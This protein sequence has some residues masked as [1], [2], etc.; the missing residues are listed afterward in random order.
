[1][2]ERGAIERDL[3]AEIRSRVERTHRILIHAATQLRLGQRAEA[4]LVEMWKENPELL[5]EC[6]ALDRQL[7]RASR[8]MATR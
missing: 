1:M 7:P 3:L 6:F 8:R 5:R 4:V 2:A